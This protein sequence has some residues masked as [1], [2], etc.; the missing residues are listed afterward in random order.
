MS[1]T[2]YSCQT[3]F[4]TTTSLLKHMRMFCEQRTQGTMDYRCGEHNCFRHFSSSLAFK[5]HLHNVHKENYCLA[6]PDDSPSSTIARDA[7]FTE[8]IDETEHSREFNTTKD[9]CSQNLLTATASFLL[10]LDENPLLPRSTV[11]LFINELHKFIL[12]TVQ[13]LDNELYS[14][15]SKDEM[16]KNA[17][18]AFNTVLLAYSNT[19]A[20]FLTEYKRLQHF[21]NLGTYIA[22]IQVVVGQRNEIKRSPLGST[23]TNVNCTMQVVPIKAVLQKFFSLPGVLRDTLNY[24]NYLKSFT[25][26]II[27]LV[28]GSVW[29][30]IEEN[31]KGNH[32]NLPLLIYFDDIELNNVLGSRTS[33]QKIGATYCSVPVLP[34]EYISKLKNIFMLALFH[35]SDRAQ[36]GNEIIF[37]NVIDQLNDLHVN[38]IQVETSVYS[39]VIKFHV[40][41]IIGD[42]LG[43]NSILGF[44]ESFVAKYCCRFCMAERKQIQKMLYE[45]KKLLRNCKTYDRCLEMK[46]PTETGVKERCVWLELEGFK[47]FEHISVDILHDYLEGVCRYVM[48]FVVKYLVH[49]SKLLSLNILRAKVTDFDYGPDKSSSPEHCI[50]LDGSTVRI[51][52]TAAEMLTLVRYFSLMFGNYVTKENDVWCLFLCLREL[53]DRLLNSRVYSDTVEI[54][55]HLVATLNEQYCELSKLKLKPKFHFL[56]HY[57]TLMERYGPLQQLWTMR[58]E[59]RHRL[60]KITARATSSRVN[61]CKTLSIKNQLIMNSVLQGNIPASSLVFGK[62]FHPSI[63]HKDLIRENY[64]SDPEHLQSVKWINILGHKFTISSIITVDVCLKA[65]HPQF[66]EVIAIFIDDNRDVFFLGSSLKTIDF[67]DHLFA[68]KVSKGGDTVWFSYKD[69]VNPVPNHLSVIKNKMYVTLRWP[70]D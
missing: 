64:E 17:Q 22:P 3:L 10:T 40:A 27:N 14:L 23:L 57:Q 56:L 47:L 49:E 32:I 1:F 70:L 39:G 50:V 31:N 59:A 42:N 16:P 25:N 48:E 45:D 38:G 46:N 58:F 15:I 8:T 33:L 67:D 4:K 53:L 35:A 54:I 66:A 20:P 5:R 26:P 36:F 55:S 62:T 7:I 52:T 68:Y 60:L 11:Q 44:V 12:N 34:P 2:C 30:D 43:L 65:N 21:E 61:I 63:K 13:A 18:L 19:F 24:L 37:K 28:Q 9:I 41:S 69:L 6:R 51:K 29:K